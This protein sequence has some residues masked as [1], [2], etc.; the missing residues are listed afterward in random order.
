LVITR[1]NELIESYKT[2]ALPVNKLLALYF[3]FPMSGQTNQEYP[4]TIEAIYRQADDGIFFSSQLCAE[5]SE[6]ADQLSTAF[7]KRFGKGAPRVTKPDFAK[8]KDAELMPNDADYAD[9]I[10][11][12]VRRPD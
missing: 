6:H 10:N 12:F 9:W 3:G 1:R 4:D 8:A 11:M 5:L 2:S 7:K